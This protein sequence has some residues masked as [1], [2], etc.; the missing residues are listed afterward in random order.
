MHSC[1]FHNTQT[2]SQDTINIDS[3]DAALYRTGYEAAVLSAHSY[4][5]SEGDYENLMSH[6]V[7][8]D[9]A[10]RRIAR[11]NGDSQ[12]DIDFESK[13]C[14][15]LIGPNAAPSS[16]DAIIEMAQQS[17]FLRVPLDATPEEIANILRLLCVKVPG[18]FAPPMPFSKPSALA[19][20]S[21]DE[22]SIGPRWTPRIQALIS[23]LQTV[24]IF[25][26]DIIMKVSSSS[27]SPWRYPGY[28]I[29]EIPRLGYAQI[30]LSNQV[31]EGTRVST[32]PLHIDT[33]RNSTKKQLDQITGVSTLI[34]Q[35]IGQWVD[36]LR[37]ILGNRKH[38]AKI[39]LAL[40]ESVRNEL[41]NQ[42]SASEF[43]NKP[44]SE[45]K[46]FRVGSESLAEIAPMLL[47]EPV[48]TLDDYPRKLF[49]IVYGHE[50]LATVQNQITVNDERRVS[51]TESC[52]APFNYLIYDGNWRELIRRFY[53]EVKDFS[54]AITQEAETFDAPLAR[55]LAT[56]G[57]E[58][59][60]DSIEEC[61]QLTSQ[62]YPEEVS[63]PFVP[64]GSRFGD[65][66]SYVDNL[67]EIF[68]Q[69]SFGL[70]SPQRLLMVEF[71]LEQQLHSA[72]A[73]LKKCERLIVDPESIAS[74]LGAISLDQMPRTASRFP[75]GDEI[76]SL[77][78]SPSS[79][80]FSKLQHQEL[81]ELYSYQLSRQ[82]WLS[83]VK[84][85]FYHIKA[86]HDERCRLR[87]SEMAG[88]GPLTNTSLVGSDPAW[89]LSL[90]QRE[91]LQ[92]FLDRAPVCF[93]HLDE[94]RE[95]FDPAAKSEVG[96]LRGGAI[97][98]ANAINAELQKRGIPYLFN[99]EEYN[100]GLFF[101]HE[102]QGGP[103]RG[104]SK[105]FDM[106]KVPIRFVARRKRS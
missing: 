18:V 33:Y 90:E 53:P 41:A 104:I 82:R 75:L 78:D 51:Q 65:P 54:T 25:T 58:I 79:L 86:E 106:K 42:L 87:W 57:I 48:Y 89:N 94:I 103:T 61:K 52:P 30:F 88:S 15:L 36:S 60:L 3:Q 24:G 84:E 67:R 91:F 105:R 92:F 37:Q 34:C 32:G 9:E 98:M 81:N 22:A 71:C 8:M 16:V 1:N 38:S 46:K 47:P 29:L 85:E 20:G 45:L 72:T 68:R 43:F 40:V 12:V 39:P 7:Q 11:L 97:K 77:L 49:E 95:Y 31:G 4:S 56:C 59:D 99:R 96:L 17:V 44:W 70:L 64:L 23:Y 74:S 6:L 93:R 26:D 5:G 2:S 63:E 50:N 14:R 80:H 102:E 10:L 13:I 35:S 100:V 28:S 66:S 62:L 69:V 83:L 19:G 21:S 55:L 76:T 73:I 27:G 101:S